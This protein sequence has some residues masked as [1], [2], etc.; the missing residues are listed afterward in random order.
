MQISIFVSLALGIA[1]VHAVPAG[2]V[3]EREAVPAPLALAVADSMPD[4][5]TIAQS[6]D[7]G[8][9]SD[10][11]DVPDVSPDGAEPEHVQGACKQGTLPS[12]PAF[13]SS[14]PRGPR[15]SE[16]LAAVHR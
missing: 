10:G 3:E 4:P 11:G 15:R 13:F 14:A 7:D 8:D 6:D 2:E 12:V 1:T 16:H 9:G 5:L